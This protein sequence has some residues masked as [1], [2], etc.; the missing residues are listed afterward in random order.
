[1]RHEKGTL[2]RGDKARRKSAAHGGDVFVIVTVT[3]NPVLDRTLTVPHILFD[4]VLRATSVR[5]DWGGKGFNVSR[6]LLSLGLDSLAMG[7]V[8][9]ATGQVLEQGL[10]SLGVAT[11]FTP[12]TGETRTNTVVCEASSDRYVKVNEPGPTV[13]SEELTRFFEDAGARA[14]PADI[15]VL[16][17]SLPPGVPGTFYAQLVALLGERGAR[18]FLDTSGEALRLSCAAAP[19]LVKPNLLEASEATGIELEGPGSAGPSAA[20][21]AVRRLLDQ[22]IEMVAL[23]LGAG[24]LLLATA[25]EAVWAKS[26]LVPVRNPTGAGDALLAGVIY[27]LVQEWPL[28]QVAGWGAAAGTVSAMKEGVASGSRAE[29]EEFSGHVSVQREKDWAGE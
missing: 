3:P 10:Q 24:G 6:A 9:G 15:W 1:V 25:Q 28:E 7:F 11:A 16:A 21:E 23:S 22:G 29:V 5:L 18:V 27:A 14:R 20:L 13:Q 17:G 8:G 26:P 4:E 19:T 2:F 12:I